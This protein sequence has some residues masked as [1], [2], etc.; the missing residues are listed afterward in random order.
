MCA[1]FTRLD[2]I[3]ID[4]NHKPYSWEIR[5]N[6]TSRKRIELL[7]VCFAC[8]KPPLTLFSYFAFDRT[9]ETNILPRTLFARNYTQLLPFY[10]HTRTNLLYAF[11]YL[12][13]KIEKALRP[14]TI[15][16]IA[17]IVFHIHVLLCVYSMIKDIYVW[18]VFMNWKPLA[19][20]FVNKKWENLVTSPQFI[21]I[22]VT[23]L[24][25]SSCNVSPQHSL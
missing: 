5:L 19:N 10:V 18:Y 1:W 7:N 24:Q 12:I 4:Q 2:N 17:S 11:E 3:G 25:I 6:N 8:T 13:Y 23:S 15:L 9:P 22:N 16:C 21:S 14:S 20:A